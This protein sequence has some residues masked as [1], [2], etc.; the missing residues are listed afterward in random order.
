LLLFYYCLIQFQTN[1]AP[2]V[3]TIATLYF[4]YSSLSSWFPYIPKIC[5]SFG[6][7]EQI[8]NLIRVVSSAMVPKMGAQECN[9]FLSPC[10]TKPASGSRKRKRS[11]G[12]SRSQFCCLQSCP[13]SCSSEREHQ[14]SQ[15]QEW[16]PGCKLETRYATQG[17]DA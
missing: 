14:P 13:P 5:T 15:G 10:G 8:A 4:I 1:E 2:F 12:F 11:T 17:V 7:K 6:I 3:D 16:I 9:T